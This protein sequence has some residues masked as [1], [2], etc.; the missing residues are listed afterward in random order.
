L[1][2]HVHHPNFYQIEFSEDVQP[3]SRES[4]LAT[5]QKIQQNISQELVQSRCGTTPLHGLVRSPKSLDRNEKDRLSRLVQQYLRRSERIHEELGHWATEYFIHKTNELYNSGTGPS[6]NVKF[7]RDQ[8]LANIITKYFLQSNP[9]NGVTV[10]SLDQSNL[11]SDKATKLVDLV[12]R[13]GPGTTGLIFVKERVIVSLLFQILSSHPATSTRFQFATF[14]GLS[15]NPKK[16]AGIHE[17]LDV[18]SQNKS[19]EA[20]RIKQKHIIIAT[21]VLEEGI[22]V[23]ACNLVICFDPPSTLKS[24][25]QRRGRARNPE[26][27]FIIMRPGTSTTT[28]TDRWTQ[29]EADVIRVC[30]DE[31][32]DG[33]TAIAL[34]DEDEHLDL[35]LQDSVTGYVSTFIESQIYSPN[36]E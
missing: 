23:A 8:V 7:Y 27:R 28:K 12:A 26:S 31:E 34:E 16:T 14:V 1:R 35:T 5:L 18:E 9:V 33:D 20:F 36:V 19:L 10:H 21:D 17:L 11:L 13:Q 24:F 25:I 30:Q 3:I 6:G 15:S 2:S 22:D 32:R 29:L 4:S